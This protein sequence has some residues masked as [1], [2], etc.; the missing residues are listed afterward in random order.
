M[1][2][3]N[4]LKKSEYNSKVAK[5]AEEE[6][7]FDASLSRY[8][9]ALY[10]KALFIAKQKK[11]YNHSPDI[12]NSHIE[13]I[14]DFY[15]NTKHLLNDSETAFLIEFGKLRRLRNRSDYLEHIIPNKNDFILEFKI[16]YEKINSIMDKLIV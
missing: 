8:Y 5:W 15:K 13:F 4:L 1:N 6:G 14:N 3:I 12:K 10:E 2:K 11:F 9:Y 7:L 16:Y